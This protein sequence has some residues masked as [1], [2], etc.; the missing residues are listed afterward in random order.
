M[1]ERCQSLFCISAINSNRLS[2]TKSD[3]HVIKYLGK[4]VTYNTKFNLYSTIRPIINSIRNTFNHLSDKQR[5]QMKKRERVSGYK[6]FFIFILS[7]EQ[8]TVCEFQIFNTEFKTHEFVQIFGI[9]RSYPDG[10]SYSQ[11]LNHA[12]F[13]LC[14]S[15]WRKFIR[16]Q[17]AIKW[18]NLKFHN[19][20]LMEL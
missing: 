17:L 13:I 10:I 4:N 18:Q 2:K 1:R 14:K 8:L 3:H 20:L 12:N 15:I 16:Q 5:R 19:Q 6:F 7:L 11:N 9:Q